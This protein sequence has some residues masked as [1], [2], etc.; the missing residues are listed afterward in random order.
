KYGEERGVNVNIL[1]GDRDAYQLAS[2]TTSVWYT[3][4]GIS[5]IDKI[6]R[7]EVIDRYGVTPEDLIDV[8]GLMGDKSDNIPGVPGV[9]EKTALKLIKEYKTIE[10]VYNN[11]ENIKG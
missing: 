1:T 3:K 7:E 6:D 10:E 11:I 4:K 5:D 8:K 9:G 2:D